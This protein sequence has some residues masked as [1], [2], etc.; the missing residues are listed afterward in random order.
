METSFEC[1]ACLAKQAVKIAEDF[2][3]DYN[4]KEK[5][6]RSCLKILSESSYELSSPAI[7]YF[8]HSE[9][10]KISNLTD[11]YEAL[12]EFSNK[13][14]SEIH[15]QIISE[16]WL[17]NAD[18]PF[19]MACRLAIAGNII[20]YSAGID[21]SYLEVMKSVRES[22]VKKLYGESTD[23]LYHRIQSAKSIL[24]LADNAGEVFF[25]RFLLSQIDKQKL[26]L[27]VK[28]GPIVNDATIKDATAADL[29]SLVNTVIETGHDS[30]GI[31]LE[32]CSPE[33]IQK[34]EAAD[35]II[36]KGMANFE[37]LY[38]QT[39]KEV[40]YLFR[41][42]CNRIATVVGCNKMEYVIVRSKMQKRC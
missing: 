1:V 31:M 6:L 30:Q 26:T 37:T 23:L 16:K 24:Y 14:S 39:D 21:V 7:S 33:F 17:E 29:Y 5:I 10:K 8:M 2:N 4:A 9:A 32:Y 18:D 19:N 15:N 34:F 11:P 25:D 40:F 35:L 28:G 22:I 42:K 3:G 12:K 20:D 13:I 38:D 27:V 36:S 41:A